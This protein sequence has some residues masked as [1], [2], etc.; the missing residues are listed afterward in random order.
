MKQFQG[1]TH[2]FL[3]GERGAGKSRTALRAAE[4]SGRPCYGFLTRFG[5]E[6]R[7]R[8]ALY[9]VPP[10]APEQMDEAHLAAVRKDGRMRA[11][12]GRFDLLGTALLREAEAHPEG[13]ILMDELGHLEKDA[14]DF[15]A[16]IQRC[17]DG[18]IPV[19]GVL[20]R[21]QAWHR[22]ILEHP[23]VLV[24]TVNEEDR[25]AQAEKIAAWLKERNR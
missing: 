17:L 14:K 7:Q 21:D 25:K 10:Y 13:L 2:V 3:T 24:L 16:E 6:N 4:M 11:L 20:R 12:P 15:Q 23:R 18:E 19:I 5:G 22:F 8:S 9:M 1:K